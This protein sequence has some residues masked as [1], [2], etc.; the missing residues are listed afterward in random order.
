MMEAIQE[1]VSG[2]GDPAKT[3]RQ[4]SMRGREVSLKSSFKE[5]CTWHQS[6]TSALDHRC[7]SMLNNTNAFAK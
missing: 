5:S 7:L 1:G 4:I 2:L 6:A 3:L